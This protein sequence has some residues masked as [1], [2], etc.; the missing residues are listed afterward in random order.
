MVGFLAPSHACKVVSSAYRQGL[1]WP[2]YVWI[3]LDNDIDDLL[4]MSYIEDD[5]SDSLKEAMER[6]IIKLIY[7]GSLLPTI[8]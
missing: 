8:L 3:M 7:T 5:T 2:K 1:T 4:S 6:I